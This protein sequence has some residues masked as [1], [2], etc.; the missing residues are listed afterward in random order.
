[1]VGFVPQETSSAV[2]RL[3]E[4]RAV[5]FAKTTVSEFAYFGVGEAPLFGRTS[6]PWDLDRTPSGSS[7][8]AGAAVAVIYYFFGGQFLA[9]SETSSSPPPYLNGTALLATVGLGLA[10]Y[11][12]DWFWSRER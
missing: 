1:M 9:F 5:V 4:A 8:G 10:V 11:V 3:I 12:L 6:N 7:S 2:E